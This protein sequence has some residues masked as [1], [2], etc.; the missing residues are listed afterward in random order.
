MGW[1]QST[2]GLGKKIYKQNKNISIDLK[3]TLEIEK[4]ELAIEKNVFVM[5]NK[6]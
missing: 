5:D 3:H 2:A 4:T 6:N 1:N